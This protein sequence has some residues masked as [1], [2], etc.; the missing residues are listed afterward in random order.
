[1]FDS[2]EKIHYSKIGFDD[3]IIA[4]KHADDKVFGAIVCHNKTWVGSNANGDNYYDDDLR[5][6]VDK[7]FNDCDLYVL[8]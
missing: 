5:A 4:Y 1:M 8:L 2:H 7:M 3:C 6:I